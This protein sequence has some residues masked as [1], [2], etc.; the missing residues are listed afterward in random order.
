MRPLFS[1]TMV[2]IA[3]IGVTSTATASTIPPRSGLVGPIHP[4]TESPSGCNAVA[5]NLVINCGFE[6]GDLTGWTVGGNTIN[7]P[8]GFDG[9]GYGVDAIDAN[10]G[11]FGLYAGPI[12]SPM[13]LYQDL[14]LTAST[15]YTISFF[16]E[17][18]SAPITNPSNNHDFSASIDNTALTS[19]LASLSTIT[20]N[21]SSSGSFIPYSYTFTP[22]SAQLGGSTGSVAL[23]FSFQNDDNYWSFDDVSVTPQAPPSVPEPASLVLA[24]LGTAILALVARRRARAL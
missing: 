5:G 11:N 6:T 1:A 8:G 24:G 17:Q 2:L 15:T 4:V 14:V 3:V 20:N 19:T 7:P 22:T 16:L 10:S 9:S 13:T 18:D 12:G 23:L 21:L